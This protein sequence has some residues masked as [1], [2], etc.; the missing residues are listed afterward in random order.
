MLAILHDSK[1]SG[2]HLGIKK[3][4]HKVQENFYFVGMKDY[5]EKY[6]AGCPIFQKVKGPSTYIK[7]KSGIIEG[8]YSWDL[9]CVN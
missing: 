1:W 6:V 4:Y 2:G 5:I 3:T 9:V 7:P 8:H